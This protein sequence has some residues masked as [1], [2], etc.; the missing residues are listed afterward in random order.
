MAL[1]AAG[2]PSE[3]PGVVVGDDGTLVLS[4]IGELLGSH[5]VWDRFPSPQDMAP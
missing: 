1:R 2:I 5:R 3:A 4:Q